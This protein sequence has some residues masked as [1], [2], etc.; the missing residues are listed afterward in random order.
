MF[1]TNEALRDAL[2]TDARAIVSLGAFAQDQTMWCAVGG[3]RCRPAILV[4]AGAH[5]DETSG[6]IAA[7]GLLSRLRT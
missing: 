3:S 6:L 1:A 7:G 5:A 2:A 4:T